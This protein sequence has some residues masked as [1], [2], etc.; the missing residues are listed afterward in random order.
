VTRLGLQVRGVHQAVSGTDLTVSLPTLHEG[1]QILARGQRRF[2]AGIIGRRF[3]KTT[4]GKDRAC[5]PVLKGPNSV[6]WFAPTYKLLKDTWRDI[7]TRLGP[8]IKDKSE[9]E[10]R[11]ELH[12]GGI[13]EMWTLDKPD[14]GRGKDYRRIIVDEAG[15]VRDLEN[16]W[17]AD[18]RP[19]L[20]LQQ[21]DAWFL[22]TPKGRGFFHTLYTKGQQQMADPNGEWGSW[23]LGS[24]MNPLVPLAEIEAARR[25]LPDHVFRQEYLGEPAEDGGN[26]FGM[27]AIQKC[28]NPLQLAEIN[29]PF[30]RPSNY[31]GGRRYAAG[32]DLARAEDYTVVTIF[33]VATG[34]VVALDHFRLP[35][36]TTIPRV[37][38]LLV[39]YKVLTYS[40]DATG[41][42]D[43]AG[44]DVMA[45]VQARYSAAEGFLYVF[46]G[47]SKQSLMVRLMLALSKGEISY[48]M[49]WLVAELESFGYEY[50]ANGVRYEAPQGLHDDGVMSLALAVHARDRAKAGAGTTAAQFPSYRR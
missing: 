19:T 4:F 9:D 7:K 16:R 13:I 29:V 21:G 43:K 18:I 14:A 32:I 46:T 35:W 48:P 22:G 6:G 25:D 20:T 42:G 37:V 1:Q 36:E 33:D 39:D 44:R 45:A 24:V 8:L 15:L 28:T 11:I 10:H 50:T 41:V 23:R 27:P 30:L 47:P 5:R 34:E 31:V 12:T 49:G 17:N 2:N 38:Q 40:I 3:G 26:P